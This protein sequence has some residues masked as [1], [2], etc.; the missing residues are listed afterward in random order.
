[1]A[2]MSGFG[3]TGPEK[4]YV[5]YGDHLTMASGLAAS[6]G[7]PDDPYT[8]IGTFYGDPVGGMFAAMGILAALDE[9]DRGAGGR[10]LDL[11]QLEGLVSLLAAPLLR[12]SLGA[13]PERSAHHSPAMSP[14]GFYRCLGADR[15]VAIA[16]RS[17]EEWVRFRELL[18]GEGTDLPEV[19]TLA[20]RK[21]VEADLDRGVGR[22]TVE[23]SPWQVTAACQA[24]GIAAIPV[25]DPADLLRD[26]HLHERGHL[27]W[28]DRPLTGPG[29]IPGVVFRLSG[30]AS[31][32]RSYAPLL[33][34][35]NEE[36]FVDL[37]GLTR[38]EF[39]D[40]V[41]TGVIA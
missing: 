39:D 12:T 3:S 4:T 27:Q 7:D 11:A 31:R 1:M 21:A 10:W 28:I 35:H 20:D 18:A 17:D 19:A 29:P 32:V 13:A 2:S 25:L 14:H 36:I 5:S 34:E 38:Q 23:R 24:R 40:L 41:A 33:G 9:R 26:V 16:V 22:W 37:L 8:K 15:W 6:T 30:G